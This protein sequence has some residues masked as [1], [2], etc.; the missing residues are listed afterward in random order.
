MEREFIKFIYFYYD[1]D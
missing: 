1:N